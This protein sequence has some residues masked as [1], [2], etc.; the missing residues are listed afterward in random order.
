MKTP[1]ERML[2]ER[3]PVEVRKHLSEDVH[4]QYVIRAERK[5]MKMGYKI[6]SYDDLPREVKDRLGGSPDVCAEKNGE[7]VF[8][9]VSIT[10]PPHVEKYLKA[11]KVILILP[12]E[13]GE[14][15][16]VWGEKEL[17]T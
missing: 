13:T 4:T 14:A 5:L 7:W 1:T 10:R 17:S 11:G 8:V 9:E 6:Y 2:E 16:E 15:V 3:L 12:I